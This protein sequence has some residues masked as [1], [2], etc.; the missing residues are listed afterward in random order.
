MYGALMFQGVQHAAAEGP[1][2]HRHMD[3]RLVAVRFNTE[4]RALFRP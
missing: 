4:C 1:R 2:R 3:A